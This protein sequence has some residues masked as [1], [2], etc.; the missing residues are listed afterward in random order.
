MQ[1]KI[2]LKKNLEGYLFISPWLIGFFLFIFGPILFSLF[3]SLSKWDI[4]TPAQFIGFGNY[5]KTFKDELF[6]KSLR[7]TFTFVLTSV[8]IRLLIAL[9]FAML[10]NQKLR[11]V[12]IFRTIFYLPVMLSGVILGIL[13][14]WIYSPD[15]GLLNSMLEIIGIKGPRW[16]STPRLAM[17]SIIVMSLWRVGGMMVIFLAGLQDIPTQLYD[18]AD[19][20]GAGDWM[21]FTRITIPMLTPSIFFNFVMSLIGTFQIFGEVQVLTEGGPYDSTLVYMI[22]LYQQAFEFLKMGYGSAL[23]WILFVIILAFTLLIFKS[24]SLWVFYGGLRR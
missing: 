19:I 18:A 14:A 5:A 2:S 22:H 12:T 3:V 20:D 16:L 24:S 7:I 11:G 13:W 1:M 6:W 9:T 4:I 10:L 21:K 17:T 23:A 8:P 15:Y